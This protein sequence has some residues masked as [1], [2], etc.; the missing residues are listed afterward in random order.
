M[1]MRRGVLQV[2]IEIWSDVVCPWCYIGKRNFE[3]ALAQFESRD[4]VTIVHRAFQLD[5]RAQSPRPTLESLSEKYGTEPEQARAMLA[6]V[7]EVARLAGLKYRLDE[8]LSGNTLDAHRLLLWAQARGDAQ[9]LLSTMYHAYFEEAES[10]FHHEHLLRLIDEA[11]LPRDEAAT[12]LASN[13]YE[14]LVLEDQ[15]LAASLGATGVPFF[16]IDRKYGLS[17]A[18]PVETFTAVLAKAAA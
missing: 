8:T 1:K 10:L 5:P 3:V 13:A 15:E 14:E 4:D 9:H 11:G 6:R 16:V 7:T 18:Q 2:L 12:V 17:G